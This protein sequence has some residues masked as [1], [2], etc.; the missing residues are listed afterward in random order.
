MFGNKGK[1][2]KDSESDV[3]NLLI[4]EDEIKDILYKRWKDWHTGLEGM[5]N[6]SRNV[7]TDKQEPTNIS[8]RECVAAVTYHMSL[9]ESKLDDQVSKMLYGNQRQKR[10]IYRVDNLY[11]AHG[12][13]EFNRQEKITF[14]LI[15]QVASNGSQ[16]H[17]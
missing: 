1:I 5:W 7:K 9:R 6:M 12:R 11:I 13:F 17:I 2:L 3:A 10:M 4:Q 14:L 15:A 16:D 8:P